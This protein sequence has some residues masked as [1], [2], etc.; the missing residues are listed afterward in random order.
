M[1]NNNNIKNADRYVCYYSFVFLEYESFIFQ[2]REKNSELEA[3]LTRLNEDLADLQK[4]IS[5]ERA[6]LHENEKNQ[7]ITFYVYF[8][9]FFTGRNASVHGTTFINQFSASRSASIFA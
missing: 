8:L 2:F 3:S 4:E 1:N 7:A 5:Q 6:R 9:Y